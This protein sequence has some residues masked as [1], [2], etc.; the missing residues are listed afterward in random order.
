MPTAFVIDLEPVVHVDGPVS[1]DDI[2]R[3]ACYLLEDPGRKA[4]EQQVKSFAAWPF[5]AMSNG[6]RVAYRWRLNSL[7]DEPSM[8]AR[9]RS[10]LDLNPQ[11]GRDRPARVLGVAE[12]RVLPAELCQTTGCSSVK[13]AFLSPLRFSRNGRSYPLPDPVLIHQRLVARWNECMDERLGLIIPE[14]VSRALSAAVEIGTFDLRAERAASRHA[15][16]GCVG[17]AEFH[18]TDRSRELRAVFGA[19][20]RFAEFSGLGK[21]TAHGYGAVAVEPVG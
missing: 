14:E 16:I 5:V 13:V 20:W 11:V 6:Q 10:R 2:H 9:V 4:H 21:E 18:L 15:V 8:A 1:H 17:T 3:L 12:D 19:L 7:S